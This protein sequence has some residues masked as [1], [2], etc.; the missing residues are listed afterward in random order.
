MRLLDACPAPA[1]R[2]SAHPV[3]FQVERHGEAGRR[4]LRTHAKDLGCAR[5]GSGTCSNTSEE[6]DHVERG[7]GEKLSWL[8]VWCSY[9]FT[10][11]PLACA[12]PKVLAALVSRQRGQLRVHRAA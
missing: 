4:P 11:S 8:Q 9:A 7:V 12:G 10:R 3:Y 1:G 2:A 5:Y 6:E